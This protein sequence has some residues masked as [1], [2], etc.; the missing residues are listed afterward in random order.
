MTHRAALAHAAQALVRAFAA[1]SG[2]RGN[3]PPSQKDRPK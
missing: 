2:R 1:K 3:G